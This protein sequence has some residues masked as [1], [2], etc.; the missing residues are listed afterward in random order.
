MKYSYHVP[1]KIAELKVPQYSQPGNAQH[2]SLSQQGVYNSKME[3][4]TSSEKWL[5]AAG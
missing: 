1:P 4:N 3:K 5:L 2:Q